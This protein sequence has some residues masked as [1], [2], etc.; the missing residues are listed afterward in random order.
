MRQAHS[1]RGTLRRR[2]VL[3]TS[4]TPDG[5]ELILS[6]EGQTYVFRV[7]GLTLMSSAQHGSE[8]AMAEVAAAALGDRAA[9][10]VLVGGLG[11]GY[12]LRAALDVFPK[13]SIVVA[14]LLP[15]VIEHNRGVL[16]DLAARPLDDPR[17]RVFEGDVRTPL[18][19]S[20]W[21]AILLDVD[22]GPDPF[23]TAANASLY[24]NAGVALLKRSLADGGVCVIWSASSSPVF[25]K[26]VTRAGLTCREE[27]I[28]SRGKVK[29]GSRHT[30]FVIQRPAT[31]SRRR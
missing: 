10:R 6:Q 28:F 13:S 27:R 5:Q 11:M 25:V 23:T 17:V 15:A 12:T 26:R 14:E 31:R 22:N 24:S 16:A 21:D 18:R 7:G 8:E 4:K 30:L 19:E 20:G 1:H 3:S 9:R 2:V 29:K